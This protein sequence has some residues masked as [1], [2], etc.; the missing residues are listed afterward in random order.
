MKKSLFAIVM[1]LFLFFSG[2]NKNYIPN[3]SDTVYISRTGKIH[4]FNNCSGMKYYEE[5]EFGEA[6]DEGYVLC[7]LCFD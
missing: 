2:C 3:D 5:M 1:L 7:K 6:K 4:I